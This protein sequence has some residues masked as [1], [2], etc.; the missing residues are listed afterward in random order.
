MKYIY[1]LLV[2]FLAAC[3]PA[4]TPTPEPSPNPNP[5]PN[6][7]DP[8]ITLS[9]SVTTRTNLDP[10]TVTVEVKN[11][12][13]VTSVE[14]YK[15][16]NFV[17][18][19]ETAPY[20][21]KVTAWQFGV[22]T[23]TYIAKATNANGQ[24]I[25]S[26]PLSININV[27]QAL[28]ISPQESVLLAGGAATSFEA[29]SRTE[30]TQESVSVSWTLEGPG[31]L[32]LLSGERTQYTPPATLE[33]ETTATVTG[34]LP[35]GSSAKGVITLRPATPTGNLYNVSARVF[36]SSTDIFVTE[37]SSSSPF[38]SAVVKVNGTTI[39][40]AGGRFQGALP[41]PIV[42][43]ETVNLEIEVPEGTI[44]ASVVMPSA[45]DLTAPA[46]DSSVS[47]AD[48]LMLTWT[49]PESPARFR[50]GYG[51]DPY[52]SELAASANV[53]GDSRNHS[54]TAI[55][56]NKTLGVYV[57]AIN[58]TTEATGPVALGFGLYAE[59]SNA[60]SRSTITTTP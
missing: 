18:S 22:F 8:S 21:L 16:A 9:S 43:G 34:T 26:S 41:A 60:S 4:S 36:G 37:S 55:P 57:I 28:W 52:E 35:D 24:T 27:A 25:S 45:P 33:G 54:F 31:S 48:P 14:F 58:E 15:N 42:V 39:P 59:N 30:E 13:E 40:F 23:D 17:G 56:T 53:S 47:A 1:L 50:L 44:R 49:M 20:E 51:T 46:N 5:T 32:S 7:A 38:P 6:P 19:D 2:L 10:Y 11:F 3:N 29:Y 12:S